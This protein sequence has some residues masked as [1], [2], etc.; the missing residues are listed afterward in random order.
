MYEI[1]KFFHILLMF[2][3]VTMFVGGEFY[4][5]H[6]ERSGDVRA[7]RRMYEAAKTLDMVGVVTVILG[8][9]LGIITAINGNLDLTQTW[10]IIAYVLYVAIMAL[11]I[12]YWTPRSKKVLA[13]AEASPDDAMSPELAGLLKT[14]GLALIV[15]DLLLWV[16]IIFVMV[17]KP[18]S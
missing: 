7:I 17:I 11:G 12:G 3:A 15:F 6:I 1:L 4:A 8:L 14:P 13:A 18:F 10:L 5:M 9:I 16:G 2:T